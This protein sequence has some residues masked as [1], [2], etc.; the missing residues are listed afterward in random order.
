MI[1]DC[2]EWRCARKGE[3][4][5]DA[6]SGDE[7]RR[8]WKRR[9]NGRWAGLGLIREEPLKAKALLL[10]EEMMEPCQ[11]LANHDHRR[12]VSII[13]L[14]CN[15]GESSGVEDVPSK[16]PAAPGNSVNRFGGV[17]GSP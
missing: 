8:D 5:L 15:E 7:D 6:P 14:T 17:W 16:L 1:E 2:R 4:V 11:Q 13:A 10:R 9:S 3:P 12:T